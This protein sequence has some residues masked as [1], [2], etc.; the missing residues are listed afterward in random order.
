M[1]QFLKTT[2]IGGAL[3]LLPVALIVIILGRAMSLSTKVAEP[4]ANKLGA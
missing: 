1:K 2:L 4:I 3:F